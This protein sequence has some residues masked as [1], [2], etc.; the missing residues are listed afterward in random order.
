MIGPPRQRTS[1]HTVLHLLVFADFW[2]WSFQMMSLVS[3]SAPASW[4]NPGLREYEFFEGKFRSCCYQLVKDS[5][6]NLK[7][8]RKGLQRRHLAAV[9]THTLTQRDKRATFETAAPGDCTPWL[10]FIKTLFTLADKTEPP[11]N[12]LP[13]KDGCSTLHICEKSLAAVAR[14]NSQRFGGELVLHWGGNAVCC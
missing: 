10:P 12:W 11:R 6:R 13:G 4:G 9:K 1:V 3:T 8:R 5:G 2:H 7:E 14:G